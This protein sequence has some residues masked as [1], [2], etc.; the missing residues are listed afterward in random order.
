[1]TIKTIVIVG[2]GFSGTVTAIQI[3]RRKLKHVRVVLVDNSANVGRGLAYNS[4]HSECMLNV[5]VGNMSAFPD[6]PSDF[7]KYCQ[8]RKLEVTESSF[9]SRAI[10]GDYISERLHAIKKESEKESRFELVVGEIVQIKQND[11]DLTLQLLDGSEI[12]AN[13]I[14]LAS[15]HFA[16]VSIPGLELI[17]HSERYQ[18]APYSKKLLNIVGETT[19]ILLIGAGLTALDIALQLKQ[20]GQNGK[21]YLLSRRGLL[22]QPHRQHTKKPDLASLLW[23]NLTTVNPTARNYFQEI[24]NQ[25]SNSSL[26]W[27]DI[28]GSLRS[29]TPKLWMAL[30]SIEKQRFLRHLQPYWDT[31]RHRVAPEIYTKIKEAIDNDSVKVIAGKI[32]HGV[33]SENSIELN[34]RLRKNQSSKTIK[35]A[36]VIN[37]TGPNS[38]L[39]TIEN[40][41]LS[42]LRKDG[43]IQ[44]DEHGLGVLVDEQLSVKNSSGEALS[45]LSYVGP[46]LKANYWEATAVPEL[47][48][49]I[50][51]LVNRITNAFTQK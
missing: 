34:I 26:D 10:F 45:W 21:I 4:D 47:R 35:V 50:E 3:L 28:I 24:R 37:C 48:T 49:H 6:K 44:L 15:G 1:M 25:V 23:V 42:Q 36:H 33:C 41:L 9:V 18:E 31:H 30:P 46:L 27:R 43:L 22:P 51:L 14:V 40:T 2:G 17:K 19:P 32:T 29:I 8:G 7:V 5:P 13:H 11:T 16:P 39:R 38:N 20:Q 12:S